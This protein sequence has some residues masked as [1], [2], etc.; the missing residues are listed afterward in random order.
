MLPLLA[1]QAKDDKNEFDQKQTFMPN[2]ELTL[3]TMG[4]PHL[5]VTRPSA[6]PYSRSRATVGSRWLS[7]NFIILNTRPMHLEQSLDSELPPSSEGS[8]PLVFYP[9]SPFVELS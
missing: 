5:V 4:M 6:E 2:N 9:T 8:L 7:H 1:D 3:N